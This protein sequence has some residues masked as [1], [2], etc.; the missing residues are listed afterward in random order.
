MDL[1]P[2]KFAA[3]ELKL[4][5]SRYGSARPSIDFATMVDLYM[6]GKLKLDELVSKRYGFDE[7]NEAHR[8]LAA[9]ESA[10]TIVVF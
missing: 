6:S 2:N 4:I 1:D 3:K 10:R 9:G 7:I 5:G 8:A